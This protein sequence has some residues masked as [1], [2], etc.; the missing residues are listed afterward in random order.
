MRLLD[1]KTEPDIRNTR[2]NTSLDKPCSSKS[3]EK[4]D[5]EP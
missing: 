2:L 3:N 5:A 1:L 4:D